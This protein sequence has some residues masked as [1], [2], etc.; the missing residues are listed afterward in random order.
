MRASTADETDS[1]D[2]YEVS[3][4][5][6]ARSVTC[7]NRVAAVAGAMGEVE[8]SGATEFSAGRGLAS[9][10]DWDTVVF[11]SGAVSHATVSCK[12]SNKGAVRSRRTTALASS[13]KRQP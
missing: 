10:P 7:S 9:R 13:G 8:D 4:S 2:E 11:C 3:A 12:I 1:G 6:R 5:L